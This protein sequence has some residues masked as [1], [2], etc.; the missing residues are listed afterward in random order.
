VI[1]ASSQLGAEALEGVDQPGAAI[2]LALARGPSTKLLAARGVFAELLAVGH[3]HELAGWA[4]LVARQHL[5]EHLQP[6]ISQGELAVS[7][8]L[9]TMSLDRS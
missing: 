8:L 1:V 5:L 7:T 4:E 2:A 6:G 9:R 3:G